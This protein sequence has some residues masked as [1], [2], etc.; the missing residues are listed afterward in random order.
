MANLHKPTYFWGG[1]AMRGKILVEAR[2]IE[3]GG[4]AISYDGQLQAAGLNV[5]ESM[6]FLGGLLKRGPRVVEMTMQEPMNCGLYLLY[7]AGRDTVGTT[8]RKSVRRKSVRRWKS[9]AVKLPTP[10]R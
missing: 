10:I 9:P 2:P 8:H 4:V 3:D 5:I 1:C 6:V 7:V